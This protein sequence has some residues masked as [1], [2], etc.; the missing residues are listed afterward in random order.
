MNMTRD[1]IFKMNEKELTALIIGSVGWFYRPWDFSP[2]KSI[3]DAFRVVEKIENKPFTLARIKNGWIAWFGN[4]DY[5]ITAKTAPL[6]ICRA[7][8]LAVQSASPT[9]DLP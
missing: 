7:A 5:S 8:L 9:H 4:E 1:E 6:A 2:T 3:E